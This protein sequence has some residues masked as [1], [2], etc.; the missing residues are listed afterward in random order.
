MHVDEAK[1]LSLAERV[2]TEQAW[3]ELD[4]AFLTHRDPLTG[5]EVNGAYRPLF[6]KILMAIPAPLGLGSA[7]EALAGTGIARHASGR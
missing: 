5:H 4:A 6:T 3:Q 1:V 2:L 7:L